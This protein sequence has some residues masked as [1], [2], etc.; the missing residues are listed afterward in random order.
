MYK[1]HN[2]PKIC[3]KTE[4]QLN[5]I[6][7]CAKCGINLKYRESYSYVDGNNIAITNN[8]KPLCYDCAKANK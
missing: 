7:S 5:A 2:R 1:K 3:L 8:S 6:I 4:K